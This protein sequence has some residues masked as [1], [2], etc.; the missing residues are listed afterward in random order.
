MQ[1]NSNSRAVVKVSAALCPHYPRIYTSPWITYRA[2]GTRA[3]SAVSEKA[4][5]RDSDTQYHPAAVCQQQQ[6]CWMW[7]SANLIWFDFPWIEEPST[8]SNWLILCLLSVRV[9]VCA[10]VCACPLLCICARQSE[11]RLSG[12]WS[13][14]L[15]SFCQF[16]QLVAL[17][18]CHNLL[19]TWHSRT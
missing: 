17:L 16:C 6:S 9:R 10:C 11:N 19:V 12:I 4:L 3:N 8:F 5:S 15:W 13:S 1:K 7:H 14:L 2:A 18:Q